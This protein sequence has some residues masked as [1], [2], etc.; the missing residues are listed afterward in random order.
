[1]LYIYVETS[2]HAGSGSGLGAVDLPIQRE[3]VT[4]YPMVQSSS[5]KG[6]L[7]A[8]CTERVPTAQAQMI[9][10]IFGPDE[11]GRGHEFAGAFCPGDA[12]LLLFPVRSLGDIF[13]WIT[14]RDAL[15]RFRR[16]AELIYSGIDWNLPNE[17]DEGKALVIT[18]TPN[19][20]LIVGGQIVLEEFAFA[21]D[22]T[23]SDNLK[24][25]A[26]WLVAHA[27]PGKFKSDGKRADNDEYAY[28]AKKL[29]TSLVVL[30]NN[31][32]RD[33]A[34]F[35]TEV[36]TRIKLKRDT[37]TVEDGGLWTEESLPADT[38]L[39]APL[40]A[41]RTRTGK[42][43]GQLAGVV[44]ASIVQD[45]VAGLLNGQRI[46]LGGDETVGRGMVCLRFAPLR[47]TVPAQS[48]AGTTP[49]QEK[50]S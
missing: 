16:D 11:E 3:R 48:T 34:E 19:N 42:A 32:F 15:A 25:L 27:L 28:W 38:L 12:R 35:S 18:L 9:E 37:K 7:R 29:P 14:C 45:F 30:S 21:P 41:T 17:P 10:K 40:N 22:Y 5:L 31:T 46:Q 33:F 6:R 24:K 23:Q 13:A 2:L 39:Y 36:V 49:T 26:D 43:T 50:S 4:G 8:E 1:M 44:G 47:S 20:S